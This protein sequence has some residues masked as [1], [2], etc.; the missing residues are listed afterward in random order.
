MG[1]VETGFI[2]GCIYFGSILAVDLSCSFLSA[3]GEVCSI[4]IT[5]V[6]GQIFNIFFASAKIWVVF[7]EVGLDLRLLVELSGSIVS[8]SEEE[9]YV[10]ETIEESTSE[11]VDSLDLVN[12]Q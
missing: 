8:S 5:E 2:L 1:S 9:V 4:T 3:I 12:S 7:I 6:F 10:S 11:S